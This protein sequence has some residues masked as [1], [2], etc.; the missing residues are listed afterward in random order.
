MDRYKR[1]LILDAFTTRINGDFQLATFQNKVQLLY[2]PAYTLYCLQPLDMACFGPFKTVYRR[3][4]AKTGEP[5]L[6]V[7]A[8]KQ[9][10]ISIY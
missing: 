9:H 3:A 5:T 2:I 8:S 10:F 7:P 4:V 6:S 1:L